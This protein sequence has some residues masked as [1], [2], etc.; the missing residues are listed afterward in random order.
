M[1]LVGL[2]GWPVSHSKSPAMHNAAFRAAGINGFYALLPVSPD[3]I[4]EAVLGLR[5]LGFRGANVTIP[6]K[7]AVTHYLDSLTPEAQA[8]GAVNT[9]LVEEDGAL[10]GT[11]T[12]AAG[13]VRDLEMVGVSFQRL[14][15]EYALVLGAGGS[16]RAVAYAL[17]TRGVPTRILARRP[18]QARALIS[19]L[20][21]HL[22]QPA[23]LTAHP[24][25]D[26][27]SVGPEAAL[28]V[29][30]TP[31]GMTPRVQASPW[32]Q[33]LPFHVGQ[34]VY[35]LV[36]NPRRTQ[37]M[38]QAQEAGAQ[39]WNGLGM[40]VHQG[41]LAWELWTGRSAPIAI[42]RAAVKPECAVASP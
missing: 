18:E 12:D 35:D 25:S 32:P 16:A 14:K 20:S 19:T 11:N 4:G 38:K 24:W 5:A 31:V 17:A 8:I 28:I 13:F 3:R 39:A 42:M 29:N 33:D 15:Q 9:I 30:C 37:L 23:I 2:M 40:L 22:S 26:L 7:Q 36:Y 27:P 6:H 10:L 34:I 41:A 1:I 21:P